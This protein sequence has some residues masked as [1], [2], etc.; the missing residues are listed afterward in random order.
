MLHSSTWSRILGHAINPE[1]REHVL[2]PFFRRE[3]VPLTQ[4]GQR[5]FCLDG[6]TLEGTIPPGHR[7][8]VHVIA[9]DLPQE[10]A[11]LAQVQVKT[12]GDEVRG[13][14]MLL[15]TIELRGTVV[16]GDATVAARNLRAAI[17]QARGL[18]RSRRA[19][20][21]N[22]AGRRRPWMLARPVRSTKAMDGEKNGRSP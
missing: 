9:A 19:S 12:V 17:V 13:A 7:Q 16:S 2:G 6:K 1:E 3:L 21:H 10:G 15:S 5:H 20:S 22:R 8:R 14:L 4:P 11:I 18:R